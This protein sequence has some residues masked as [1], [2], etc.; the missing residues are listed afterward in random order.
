MSA[1]KKVQFYLCPKCEESHDNAKKAFDCLE[2]CVKKEAK[3]KADQAKWDKRVNKPRFEAE[4]VSHLMELIVK[5]AEEFFG[6]KLKITDYTLRFGDLSCTHDAP[7]GKKT[8]WGGREKEPTSYLGW[9]GNI[10]GKWIKDGKNRH[11]GELDGFT[12]LASW[13]GFLGIHTGC[14]SGGPKFSGEF[15]FFLDD[16]PK[17]K[18]KHKQFLKLQAKEKALLEQRALQAQKAKELSDS[19]IEKDIFIM[20]LEEEFQELDE[21]RDEVVAELHALKTEH[22]GEV[23]KNKDTRFPIS[24][25][26]SFDEKELEQL[27]RTFNRRYY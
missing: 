19:I 27:S 5:Y 17:L 14:F 26:F 3:N 23:F 8:N 12:D 20:H 10:E 7:I 2:K 15:R 13:D 11:G 9:S 1:V 21:R 4:S 16:F 24:K 22:S 6:V 25:R 18:E